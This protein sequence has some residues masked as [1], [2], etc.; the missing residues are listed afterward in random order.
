MPQWHNERSVEA[1]A[2]L[3]VSMTDNF[4]LMWQAVWSNA[5]AGGH[6]KAQIQV[7]Q[8]VYH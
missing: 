4:M 5:E 2:S 8:L 1:S 7:M 3:W 6:P